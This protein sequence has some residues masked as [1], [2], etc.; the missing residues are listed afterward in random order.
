MKR[1]AL[2]Y[3]VLHL[4]SWALVAADKPS[5]TQLQPVPPGPLSASA[6]ANIINGTDLLP[7]PLFMSSIPPPC[8]AMTN[9][10]DGSTITCPN[11]N[12]QSNCWSSEGCWVNC[13]ADGFLF[14]PGRINDMECMVW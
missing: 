1:I 8:Y 11:V 6:I 3:V 10:P 9:C 12:Y 13:E 14:C 4:C 5:P 7:K 2:A